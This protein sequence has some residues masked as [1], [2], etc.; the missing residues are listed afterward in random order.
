MRIAYIFTTFPKLSEQ[1][2]LREVLEL[3]RQGLDLDIY[4]MIGGRTASDAGPVCCMRWVDWFRFVFE[5]LYWLC[6]RPVRVIG[7][8]RRLFFRRYGSWT[9][10]VKFARFRVWGALCQKF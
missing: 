6:V 9:N 5:L 7:L 10:W 1:F 2:F 3:Q 8:L 4:S